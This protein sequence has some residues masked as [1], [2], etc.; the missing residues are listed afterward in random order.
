[1]ILQKL[2]YADSVS[3][4]HFSLLSMLKTAGTLNISRKLIHNFDN[5]L[6]NRKLKKTSCISNSNLL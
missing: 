3:K 6:M 5:S 2:L 4:K 1:M